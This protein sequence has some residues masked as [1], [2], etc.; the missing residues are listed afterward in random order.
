MSAGSPDPRPESNRLLHVAELFADA[1]EHPADDRDAFLRQVCGDDEGLHAEVHT[2]LGALPAAEAMFPSVQRGADEAGDR[3]AVDDVPTDRTGQMISHF[4]LEAPLGAGG[5]GEVYRATDVALG[6]PAAVKLLR[7]GVDPQLRSRLLREARASARLG[8][9]AIAGFYE[10]GTVDDVD[11]MAMEFVEGETLRQRLRGGALPPEEAISMIAALLEALVHSHAAGIVHR[12]IK[13]EN[14]MLT[15]DG[16]TKLLDF[17]IAKEVVGQVPEEP[18]SKTVVLRTALTSHGMIVGT[19]G[20]MSPEQL[21]GDPVNETTDV[22]SL[23]AVLYEALTGQP[24]FPGASSS[25]R[26]IS[27]LSRELPGVSVDGLSDDIDAI[28]RRAL[29]RDPADRYQTAAEFLRELRRFATGES[30]AILPNTV[31]ILDLDNVS[32]NPDDDWIGSGIAESLGADLGRGKG[33]TLVP[34]GKVLK[35]RASLS[36]EASDLDPAEVGLALGCRWVLAGTFQRMGPALRLTTRLVEVATGKDLW[37][38][39]LDGKLAEL[40]E[41]QDRLAALTAKSLSAVLP[42]H[43]AVGARRLDSY[44]LMERARKFQGNFTTDGIAQSR[45]LF[46]QIL[47]LESENAAALASLAGTYA[48]GEWART[49]DPACLDRA[50]EYGTRAIKADPLHEYAHVIVGYVKFRHDRLDEAIESFDRALQCDESS[51]FA[52]YFRCCCLM[53][54]G[55]T[56]E[57]LLWGQRAARIAPG[58]PFVLIVVGMAHMDLSDL[59]SA[60]WSFEEADRA[61][62]KIGNQGWSGAA[63]GVAECLRRMGR[64][65]EARQRCLVALD[66][67]E[68]SDFMYRNT[69]RPGGMNQL[70]RILLDSADFEGAA[71]AFRQAEANLRAMPEGVGKGHML[72]QALAGRTRA[73]EGAEPF[74][75]ALRVYEEKSMDFAWGSANARHGETRFQLA[76]AAEKLGRLDQARELIEAARDGFHPEAREYQMS[77]EESE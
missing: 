76:L 42:E 55:Q 47:E 29:A 11:F 19:V 65:E 37:S 40:F 10:S 56:A 63:L 24:A 43:G 64:L 12:D 62:L 70:G 71:V 26:I 39:K 54:K 46:E 50:L 4:R 52:A 27:V 57:G 35:V 3:S 22:F 2:L 77:G 7:T 51:Y 69:S 8:H 72:V 34:R 13:P 6:R 14:I 33:L 41:M 9:P 23:G 60:L 32:K 48:P 30:V 66:R 18:D 68:Q 31:A 59:D 74:E 45:E 73:G 25:Q 36:A 75:D 53:A 44:E 20:Y 15:A 67:L 38:E 1:L 61:E 16:A 58:L 21:R 28:L 17:G 5:M 49:G